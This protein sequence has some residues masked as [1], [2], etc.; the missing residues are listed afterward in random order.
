[1]NKKNKTLFFAILEGA[2]YDDLS[3]CFNIHCVQR[4][5]CVRGEKNIFFEGQ[6]VNFS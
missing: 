5:L 2:I 4:D 1:M 3:A 6:K